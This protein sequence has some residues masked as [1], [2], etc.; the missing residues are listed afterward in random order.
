MGDIKNQ[1]KKNQYLLET[2]GEIKGFDANIIQS[3]N[4]KYTLQF[5]NNDDAK[6]ILSYCLQQN[7][8]I[9]SYHEILPSLNEIFINLVEGNS[10]ARQFET[11]TI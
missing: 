2:D 11:N 6:N 3:N 10:A 8:G 1:Y 4:N 9:K 7:I 5:A